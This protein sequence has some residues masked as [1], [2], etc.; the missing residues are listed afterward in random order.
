LNKKFKI[1]LSEIPSDR[2]LWQVP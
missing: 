1:R 2:I